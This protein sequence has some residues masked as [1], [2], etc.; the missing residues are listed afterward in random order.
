VL[1]SKSLSSAWR[2]MPGRILCYVLMIIQWVVIYQSE[3]NDHRR[4]E[5]A[6]AL[7]VCYARP[8]VRLWLHLLWTLCIL[9]RATMTHDKRDYDVHIRNALIYN[10][11]LVIARSSRPN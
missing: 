5:C 2:M 6:C 3:Q 8:S 11:F 7:Y 9:R 10:T 1:C 4:D